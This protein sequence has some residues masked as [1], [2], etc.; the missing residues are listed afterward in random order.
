MLISQ[1]VAFFHLE[2]ETVLE[3]DEVEPVL[4]QDLR[5]DLQSRHHVVD[6]ELLHVVS[7]VGEVV[8]L[9]LLAFDH[10]F[11]V[12]S[13]L[14][15]TVNAPETSEANDFVGVPE[16]LIFL[17]QNC[18]LFGV[19]SELAKNFNHLSKM[20]LRNNLNLNLIVAQIIFIRVILNLNEMAAKKRLLQFVSYLVRQICID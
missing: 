7:D 14:L 13:A 9:E 3:N 16:T 17:K 18:V 1:T 8:L 10:K 12:F 6:E 20:A 4:P 15:A 5:P 11:C 19:G 2:F